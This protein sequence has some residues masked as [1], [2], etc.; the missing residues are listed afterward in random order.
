MLI[1]HLAELSWS[2]EWYPSSSL[3]DKSP[4]KNMWVWLLFFFFWGIGNK[5]PL[6]R[7]ILLPWCEVGLLVWLKPSPKNA[8]LVDHS[9]PI[10]LS[11]LGKHSCC[12]SDHNR[13][14]WLNHFCSSLLL[15]LPDHTLRIKLC[16][17]RKDPKSTGTPAEKTKQ[18]KGTC[19]LQLSLLDMLAPSML[20]SPTRLHLTLAKKKKKLFF[21]SLYWAY[22]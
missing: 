20:V 3:A 22:K 19:K 6:S 14:H 13:P 12:G 17:Y 1:F 7:S 4:S 8:L 5:K 16:S 18:L 10:F 15:H 11:Q 21:C 2:R 9:T